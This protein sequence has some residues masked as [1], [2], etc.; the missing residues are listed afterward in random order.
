MHELWYY[1]RARSE[2]RFK[3]GEGTFNDLAKIRDANNKQF[4]ERFYYIKNK[5]SKQ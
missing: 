1:F 5:T 4:K 3:V 2:K